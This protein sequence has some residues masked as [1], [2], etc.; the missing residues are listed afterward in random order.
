MKQN[1]SIKETNKK[2]L[3]FQIVIYINRLKL[4]VFYENDV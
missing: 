2:H 4:T 3:V 1:V